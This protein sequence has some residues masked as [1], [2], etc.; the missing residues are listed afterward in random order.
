M[1][2]KLL[3]FCVSFLFGISQL[4]LAQHHEAQEMGH[5]FVHP[6]LAHM[7][8]PDEPGE[9]SLRINPFQQRTG[10]NIEQDIGVHLEAGL[11]PRFGLHFRS[12]AIKSA[13]YSEVML[14]YAL[15]QN[16]TMSN[17][18]GLFGQVSVPTGPIKS[19]TY[20]GLFGISVRW[21]LN[22]F[23]VTDSNIHFDVKDEMQ[24]FESALVFKASKTLYPIIEFHGELMKDSKVVS[25]LLGFKFKA[26]NET[27]FGF[28]FQLPLTTDKEFDTQ[29]LGTLDMAF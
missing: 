13:P 14:M 6:F 1:R 27:A 26:G 18:I 5:Y 11:L 21:T 24:E 10:E 23:L 9:V 20:K 8:L 19:N 4:A 17:G 22:D 29:L 12:D 28:G 7:A 3:I 2:V 16:E 15:V 25:S